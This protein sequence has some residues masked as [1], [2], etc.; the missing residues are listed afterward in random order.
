MRQFM[1][2]LGLEGLEG[3][4]LATLPQLSLELIDL[5]RQALD[6]LVLPLPG[7]RWLYLHRTRWPTILLLILLVVSLQKIRMYHAVLVIHQ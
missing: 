7:T 2:L 6:I 4:Q 1:R 5:G 3:Q